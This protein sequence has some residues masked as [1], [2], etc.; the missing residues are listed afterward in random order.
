MTLKQCAPILL[1]SALFVLLMEAATAGQSPY[2]RHGSIGRKGA[3]EEQA[4]GAPLPFRPIEQWV[5][6][7][8]IFLPQTKKIQRI[9]MSYHGF[10]TQAQQRESFSIGG[11]SYPKYVGRILIVIAVKKQDRGNLGD[12]WT[13]T[14]ELEDTRERLFAETLGDSIDNIA[15]LRDIET[16]R[17]L[18]LGQVLW[19]N[20]AQLVTYDEERDNF[21]G[22][23]IKKYSPVKVT[24]IVAGW[25]NHSPVR[26]ILRS[27]AG[28][29]GFTDVNLSGTNVPD[30]L[31]PFSRFDKVFW[32][33]DPRK[34]YS[35]SP[36]VWAAIE[37][38]A[39]FIGM[40]AEQATMSWGKP[41]E[42]NRTVGAS[43]KREQWVYGDKSYLYIE[44]GQVAGLQN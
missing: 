41:K 13:I 14:F 26:F 1:I 2:I 25:Y 9:S 7:R 6:E 39:V 16:A 4:Q 21:G 11:I 38:G 30:I 32:T 42:V 36:K 29:E 17:Q 10:K 34:H 5:G 40:T 33:N 35:W 18:W 43:G 15:P 28:D 3:G 22:V 23:K 8:F 27:S 19:Y 24:D 44:N 31:R 37:E 12:Q 20:S